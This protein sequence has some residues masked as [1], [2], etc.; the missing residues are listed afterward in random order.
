[1]M[2]SYMKKKHVQLAIWPGLLDQSIAAF[3]GVVLPVL[4]IIVA[5]RFAS[6]LTWINTCIGENNLRFFIMFLFWHCCLCLYGTFLIAAII[7][8]E[9]KKRNLVRLLTRYYGVEPSFQKLFPHIIQWVLAFYSEQLLLL[10]FLGV[11]SLLLM[12]F[13]GYH[14]YLVFTNT[15]TNET[16]KWES[17]KRCQHLSHAQAAKEESFGGSPSSNQGVSKKRFKLVCSLPF[18]SKKHGTPRLKRNNIYN[19]GILQNVAEVLFPRSC[20]LW[21]ESFKSVKGKKL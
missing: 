4:I 2:E 1:M 7:A 10:L 20:Q 19:K 18:L 13:F 5:G 21:C 15:T 6:F 12:G 16:F 11:I 9:V 8:G 14:L 3:V 17:Y